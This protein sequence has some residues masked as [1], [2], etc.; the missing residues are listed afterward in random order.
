MISMIK[1]T[2]LRYPLRNLYLLYGKLTKDRKQKAQLFAWEKEGRPV[3]PPHI[4]KQRLLREYAKKYGLRVLLETGT[5]YG[6]MVEAM[7]ADFDLI[8]SIEL[9]RELYEKAAL[10][11]KRDK[12]IQ[13]I[14]GDSGIEL[15]KLMD[16]I[17]QATLFWLDG[18]YS[19]GETAKG[20]KDTPVFE[21]LCH[22]LNSPD[23]G[24][25]IIIDDAHCFGSTLS[26]PSL[27][28][29]SEFVKSKRASLD[30]CVQDNIIC[31][32]PKQ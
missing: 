17:N 29:L 23:K 24:H 4:V 9:S 32:T 14:H 8:Y 13:L 15:G 7:K 3:P 22:I 28:E 12:N 16:K 6:E 31:I 20:T 30:I 18:H 26:Y 27:K 10:R 2:P 21:E 5:F 11:F 1:K 19:A 25:I